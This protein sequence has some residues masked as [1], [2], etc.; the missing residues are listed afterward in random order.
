MR[1]KLEASYSQ[2]NEFTRKKSL[3]ILLHLKKPEKSQSSIYWLNAVLGLWH[4]VTYTLPWTHWTNL[5]QKLGCLKILSGF[6]AQKLGDTP[7]VQKGSRC[8]STLQLM[9]IGC[10]WFVTSEKG[11]YNVWWSQNI[12]NNQKGNGIFV[13]ITEIKLYLN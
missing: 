2:R 4:L 9:R 5:L 8:R 10:G 13:H 12:S 3:P 1:K 6:R 11:T 7:F